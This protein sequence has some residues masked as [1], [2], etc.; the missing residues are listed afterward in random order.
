M[1][2]VKIPSLLRYHAGDKNQIY[3]SQNKFSEVLAAL[4]HDYPLLSPYFFDDKGTLTQFI[5]FYVNDKDIRFL[6]GL[7]TEISEEDVV[8]IIPA[9]AGG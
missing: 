2:I 6:K 7:D 5:S 4:I 8:T 3:I 1:A 9:V